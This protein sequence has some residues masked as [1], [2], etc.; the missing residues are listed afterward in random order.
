MNNKYFN[1]IQD[2]F[3]DKEF[4]DIIE[5]IILKNE[6]YSNKLKI[7]KVIESI[8]SNTEK[9]LH[10][11][12][13][14]LDKGKSLDIT[15]L[16]KL[17]DY[18]NKN[19]QYYKNIL[20]IISRNNP[21]V[22]NQEIN[23]ILKIEKYRDVDESLIDL[24][25]NFSS[26]KDFFPERYYSIIKK[27]LTNKINKIKCLEILLNKIR[28]NNKVPNE[29][30]IE[31][32]NN[33]TN[34]EIILNLIQILFITNKKENENAKNL[35]INKIIHIFNNS[36]Q[37]EDKNEINYF[38][39]QITFL[40]KFEEFDDKIKESIINNINSFLIGKNDYI[41]SLF[42]IYSS[43]F[44]E[45]F[46]YLL[47]QKLEES[48]FKQDFKEL[49]QFSINKERLEFIQKQNNIVDC[50]I[51]DLTEE[52]LEGV[53]Y[54]E[55]NEYVDKLCEKKEIDK[56]S[57]IIILIIRYCNKI[58]I[59]NKESLTSIYLILNLYL[60]E[61][62]LNEINLSIRNKESIDQIRQRWIDNLL[63]KSKMINTKNYF[64]EKIKEY[65]LSNEIINHLINQL[66]LFPEKDNINKMKN[67]F[68]FI[69]INKDNQILFINSL[70][71][72][73][74]AKSYNDIIDNLI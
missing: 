57:E 45:K 11:V 56:N 54:K 42:W 3:N 29:L 69:E 20:N 62:D 58:K 60:S 64:I 61:L 6:S 49:N 21:S 70:L 38:F 53:K 30:L 19:D 4:L 10:I 55:I 23:D 63:K 73:K 51:Q 39:K 5:A 40:K 52:N 37:N 26:K 15:C 44:I 41:I 24:I 18:M 50:L 34:Y 48:T 7:Q 17:I 27:A 71:M 28:K 43:S 14:Y 33:N 13:C 22:N 12:N 46:N 68:Y 9:C 31:I 32:I 25:Y 16:K 59:M 1:I 36:S 35:L 47:L 72:V 66:L 8:D 2:N 65:Q 74:N 67:L